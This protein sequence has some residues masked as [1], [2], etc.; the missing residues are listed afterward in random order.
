MYGNIFLFFFSLSLLRTPLLVHLHLLTAA[1]N[2]RLQLSVPA[3]AQFCVIK[4]ICFLRTG[5]AAAEEQDAPVPAVAA[6]A[7]EA[8]SV[9]AVAAAAAEGASVTELAATGASEVAPLLPL[10][11]PDKEEMQSFLFPDK[12][13]M[14]NEVYMSIW[15]ARARCACV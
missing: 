4:F 7:E 15:C 9:P 2:C 1:A 11:A 3:A 6:A 12:E 14:P 5:T 13:E 10:K 8:P